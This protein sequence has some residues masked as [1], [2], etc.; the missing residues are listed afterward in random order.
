MRAR[1][2]Q[3]VG[4]ISRLNAMGWLLFALGYIAAVVFVA[5][6]R[7]RLVIRR[8]TDEDLLATDVG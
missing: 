5:E 3:S 1:P 8:E 4:V 2:R 6:G 7:A